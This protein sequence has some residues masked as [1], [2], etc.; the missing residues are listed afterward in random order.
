MALLG[1]YLGSLL[2]EDGQARALNENILTL[3]KT[4]KRSLCLGGNWALC[5]ADKVSG[6]KDCVCSNEAY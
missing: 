1:S 5:L 2:S 3:I 4:L 6:I